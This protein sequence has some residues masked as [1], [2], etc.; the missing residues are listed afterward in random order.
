MILFEPEKN[1]DKVNNPALTGW[2]GLIKN[3]FK[4]Q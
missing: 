3:S 1:K 4:I 2:D